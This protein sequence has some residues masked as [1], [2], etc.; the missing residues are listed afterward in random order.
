MKLSSVGVAALR[1]GAHNQDHFSDVA[2]GKYRIGMYTDY[3]MKFLIIECCLLYAVFMSPET[4]LANPW[5]EVFVT[6]FF[7]K[8][9]VL[10]AIDEAHCI[11]EWLVS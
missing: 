9:L 4:A 1:V 8:N 7:K 6:P 3:F 2:T 10:I 11:S 5:R